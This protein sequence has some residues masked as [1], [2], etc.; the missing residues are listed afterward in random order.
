MNEEIKEEV[1]K[2]IDQ[3]VEKEE[4]SS[5][6]DPELYNEDGTF[7]KEDED[8]M[9][10]DTQTPSQDADE[11]SGN[12]EQQEKMLSQSQVNELVGRARQEGRDSAMRDLM[13]RYGVSNDLEL[14]DIFGRG[15]A[16]DDLDYD[17][18]NQT[19]SYKEAMAENALLKTN[20]DENRFE[21]VK[22]ILTGK[23]LDVNVENINA[24]LPSHP[25]W[26]RNGE[27]ATPR[28]VLTPEMG[29]QMLDNKFE[30]AAMPMKKPATLSKLGSEPNPVDKGMSEE[31][32]FNKLYGFNR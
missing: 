29:E 14:N 17:Y 16:Y 7:K 8:T 5:T 28:Q 1:K 23:G 21:D 32:M 25:E 6:P 26:K 30:G 24:L 19:N 11:N 20:I 10:G 12:V 4:N 9:N 15:Q 31:E 18:R 27:V 13:A 22:L 3:E 2:D